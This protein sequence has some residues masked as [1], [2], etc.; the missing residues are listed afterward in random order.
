MGTRLFV[1]VSLAA[2]EL[3]RPQL[4]A[5]RPASR[6]SDRS[7]CML[8]FDYFAENYYLSAIASRRV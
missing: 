8:G 7:I 3:Q 2:S 1:D 5:T 4:R 6:L